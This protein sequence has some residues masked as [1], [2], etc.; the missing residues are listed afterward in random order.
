MG[1]EARQRG[2][3]EDA[4]STV[5]EVCRVP[6]REGRARSSPLGLPGAVAR[7]PPPAPVIGIAMRGSGPI[8]PG[9]PPQRG[10]AAA[11]HPVSAPCPIV[12]PSN[13]TTGERPPT[14]SRK[15]L[16][17][18]LAAEVRGGGRS[19]GSPAAPGADSRWRSACEFVHARSPGSPAAQTPRTD[20]DLWGLSPAETNQACAPRLPTR[21]AALT[22]RSL[23]S[24]RRGR[25]GSRA[26][27]SHRAGNGTR[28][29]PPS[30]APERAARRPS[31]LAL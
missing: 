21:A 20:G 12:C 28:S 17:M 23:R 31:G 14:G 6:S 15:T 8:L 22:G 7:R 9:R 26:R 13:R 19:R 30:P 25:T 29:P 1:R 24:C 10:D 3:A 5:S 18:D 16:E 4:S 2:F 11:A 27:T